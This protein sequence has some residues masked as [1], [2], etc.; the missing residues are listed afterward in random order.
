MSAEYF[1][2]ILHLNLIKLKR[3]TEEHWKHFYRT[4]SAYNLFFIY[5]DKQSYRNTT[6]ATEIQ[7]LESSSLPIYDAK[8]FSLLFCNNDLSILQQPGV[9]GVLWL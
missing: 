3:I 8:F 6:G 5:A 7:L 4:K 9:I 1:N 2:Y